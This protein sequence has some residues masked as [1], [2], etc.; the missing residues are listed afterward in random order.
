MHFKKI[1]NFSN[2]KRDDLKEY[3]KFKQILI[4]FKKYYDIDDY[5]L[6]DID[7]YLW[8]LGKEYYP[9]NY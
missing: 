1:D 7:N 8:Q 6:I 4:E 9:N 3:P 2:F 5:N